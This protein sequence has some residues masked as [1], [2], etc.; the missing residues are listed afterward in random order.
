MILNVLLSR[1]SIK[2]EG[3]FFPHPNTLQLVC[4]FTLAASFLSVILNS[5][6]LFHVSSNT[7]IILNVILLQAMEMW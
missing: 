5:A 7:G 2:S 4:M 1:V 3:N 6:H